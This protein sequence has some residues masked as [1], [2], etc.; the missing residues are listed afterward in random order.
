MMDCIYEMSHCE[1]IY[2][3]SL[4]DSAWVGFQPGMP[5]LPS[6]EIGA[7]GIMG[8]RYHLKFGQMI[9][10]DGLHV[11]SCRSVFSFAT[12]KTTRSPSS[13]VMPTCSLLPHRALF[14]FYLSLR[15]SSPLLRPNAPTPWSI[16]AGGS[17]LGENAARLKSIPPTVWRRSRRSFSPVR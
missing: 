1:V 4:V 5:E 16:S 6:F 14:L 11:L 8:K 9:A 2:W 3:V 13:L 12:M 10:F 17:L 15:P 7:K